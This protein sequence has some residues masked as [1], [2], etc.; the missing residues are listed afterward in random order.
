MLARKEIWILRWLWNTKCS[1]FCGVDF[2][3]LPIP[4]CQIMKSTLPKLKFPLCQNC[5]VNIAQFSSLHGWVHILKLT[6]SHCYFVKFQWWE[7]WS[8]YKWSFVWSFALTIPNKECW[9]QYEK[10]CKIVYFTPIFFRP[11][12][13]NTIILDDEVMTKFSIPLYQFASC[14]S[15]IEFEFNSMYLSSRDSI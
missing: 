8:W 14:F 1:S 9:R 12:F 3:C 15:S 4:L 10:L 7:T 5:K 13:F 2:S 11:T 6:T